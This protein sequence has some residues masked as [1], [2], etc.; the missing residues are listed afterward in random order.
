[1]T[2]P[3]DEERITS[4]VDQFHNAGLTP[5]ESMLAAARLLQSTLQAFR[6]DAARFRG[7]IGET[8]THAFARQELNDLIYELQDSIAPTVRT[9]NSLL[10]DPAQKHDGP[11]AE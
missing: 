11:P 4:A 8:A 2:K 1:M 3:Y 6:A 9:Y 10:R 5:V 7:D